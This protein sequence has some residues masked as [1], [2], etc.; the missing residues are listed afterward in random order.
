LVVFV[1]GILFMGTK[2]VGSVA[3]TLSGAVRD[4][5]NVALQVSHVQHALESIHCFTQIVVAVPTFIL[6][7][8]ATSAVLYGL[9]MVL[10]MPEAFI[11]LVLLPVEQAFAGSS[12]CFTWSANVV[13][14]LGVIVT[15]SSYLRGWFPE[16]APSTAVLW[17]WSSESEAWEKNR[18]VG[19]D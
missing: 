12:D 14:L 11:G 8:P 5:A 19:D 1:L 13:G 4:I 6:S 16:A 9:H 18:Y 15:L 7:W 10:P 3:D 17:A 2:S